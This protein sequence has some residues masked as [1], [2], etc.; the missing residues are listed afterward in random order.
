MGA[1][2]NQVEK[3]EKKYEEKEEIKNKSAFDMITNNTVDEMDVKSVKQS[4]FEEGMKQLFDTKN[5]QMKTELT[6]PL[7]LA[8]ARGEIFV[9]I[10]KSK[11]MANFIK[12]IQTL[13]VSKGRKGRSELVALVRNSQDVEGE[14]DTG[15][16][17]LAK[18]MGR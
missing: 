18:L 9:D 13:N 7:I 12:V 11:N 10:Y 15:M 5:L 2:E 14:V 1:L 6:A 4:A 17:G 3:L 8:M 16:T